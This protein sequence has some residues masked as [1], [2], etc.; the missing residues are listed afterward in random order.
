MYIS[1]FARIGIAVL[2]L[3]VPAASCSTTPTH[4]RG[5]LSDAMEKTKDD[6]EGE[7]SVPDMQRP[8]EKPYPG[9]Q[10]VYNSYQ[11]PESTYS[12]YSDDDS[13]SPAEFWLGVRGGNGN[14]ASMDMEPLADGDI[15]AGGEV[16]ENLEVD[17]FAGFKVTRAVAGSELD[18]SVKDAQLFLKA[19]LEGRYSPLPAWPVMSPYL[20]AGMGSFFMGWNFRNPLVSGSDTIS[21]DSITGFMVSVGAGIYL[22]RLEHFRVGMGIQPEMYLF[23]TVTSEGFDN[24]YFGYFDSIKYIAEIA[25][26]L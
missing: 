1:Q 8:Q 24:D 20:S 15:V 17:L 21:S 11:Q 12:G 2:S 7:R 6:H 10:P 26:K 9:E 19:G 13:Y 5:S 18:A 16:S 23:G 22:L 4:Y 25:V 14:Y 3:A